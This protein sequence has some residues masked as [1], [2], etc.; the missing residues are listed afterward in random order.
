MKV[1]FINPN[2]TEAMTFSS[3]ETAQKTT[4]EINFEGWTSFDG[5]PS[6]QGPEDGEYAIKP[7]LQL[8]KKSK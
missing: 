4:P 7:L 6:I 3:V 2:S 8:I 1:I 5:P